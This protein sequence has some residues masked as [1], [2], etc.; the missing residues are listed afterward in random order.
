[1]EAGNCGEVDRGTRRDRAGSKTAGQERRV[2]VAG[3]TLYPLELSVDRTH[4]L[5]LNPTAPLF[6]PKCDAAVKAA[7][8]IQVI[9]NTE[10]LTSDT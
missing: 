5:N 10:Q 8:R 9:A 6:R 7:Q 4:T 3:T 2:R 1:M